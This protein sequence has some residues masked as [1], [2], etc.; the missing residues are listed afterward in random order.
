MR[1]RNNFWEADGRPIRLKELMISWNL[2]QRA[3][4]KELVN[5]KTGKPMARSYLN[6][7]LNRGVMPPGWPDF[8]QA[9][10]KALQAR[11]L[12][13]EGIW[14][15]DRLIVGAGQRQA[16][17]HRRRPALNSNSRQ[18]VETVNVPREML[19]PDVLGHF[20]LSEDPFSEI[21]DFERIW[22]T[23]RL[24]GIKTIIKGAVS[25]RCAGK[26]T[27]L[28]N[29]MGELLKNPRVKIIFPNCLNRSELDGDALVAQILRSMGVSPMPRSRIERNQKAREVLEDSGTQGVTVALVIDEA[30]DLPP[31]VLISLKRLWDS[32]MLFKLLAV[33]LIGQG[34]D[35]DSRTRWGLPHLILDPLEMREFAER[36]ILVAM[37]HVKNGQME[38]YLNWRFGR[39]GG[40]LGRAFEPAAVKAL[41]RRTG[42]LQMANNIAA[43][44][45]RVAYANG[46]PLV[47]AEMVAGV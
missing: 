45:M 11:G 43:R 1:G 39:A 23:K 21:A 20:G 15:P 24:E 36:C 31:R 35:Q 33:I 22:L 6:R 28:R 12:P 26:S 2:S 9:T 32:A 14:A 29:A 10:E 16:R 4:A 46:Q 42:C 19:G 8:R 25:R 7:V 3:L 34:Q 41:A 44:A 13:I 37:P 5:P 40:E 30:H 47:T 27:I 17:G 38:G 18:G